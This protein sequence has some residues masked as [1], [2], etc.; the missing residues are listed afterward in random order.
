M[1]SLKYIF[2][3]VLIGCFIYF[4]GEEVLATI[5]YNLLLINELTEKEITSSERIQYLSNHKDVVR[6]AIFG[7]ADE[8]T[9]KGINLSEIYTLAEK[10]INKTNGILG[11]KLEL[12]WYNRNAINYKHQEVAE[13]ILKDPSIYAVVGPFDLDKALCYSSFFAAAGILHIS[14]SANSDDLMEQKYPLSFSTT[15]TDTDEAICLANYLIS[16][17][18]DDLLIISEDNNKYCESFAGEIDRVFCLKGLN[19][20]QR[21]RFSENGNLYWFKE[22][23]DSYKKLYGIKNAVIISNY[24]KDNSPKKAIINEIASTFHEGKL[25]F[26]ECISADMYGLLNLSHSNCYSVAM[27]PDDNGVCPALRLLCQKDWF[28]KDFFSVRLYK[29]LWI[30]KEA[31]DKSG[32]FEYEKIVNYMKN[33]EFNTPLGKFKFESNH[34]EASPKL[35]VM[36]FAEQKAMWEKYKTDN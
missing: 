8:F 6:V 5:K 1:K 25:F 2:I 13:N 10:E 9:S 11:R 12:V 18:I 21:V 15:T 14:P 20:I 36:S 28:K 3:F 32:S 24:F 31:I 16:N 19:V 35:S 26:S 4:C 27:F 22:I 23:I 34:F 7:N 29:S 17:K 33:N 30:L